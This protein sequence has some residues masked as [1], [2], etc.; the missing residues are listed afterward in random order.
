MVGAIGLEPTTPT[1][2]RWCSNQLSYAPEAAK[3]D[4]LAARGLRLR[5]APPNIGHHRAPRRYLMHHRFE[6]HPHCRPPLLCTAMRIAPMTLRLISLAKTS[7]MSRSSSASPAP[8]PAGQRVHRAAGAPQSTSMTR[9]GAARAAT[10]IRC[11][12]AVNRD[13]LAACHE[14]NDLVRRRRPAAARQAGQQRIHADHQHLAA[15]RCRIRA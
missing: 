7:E 6:G 10:Q 12:C 2:S 4:A 13:A 9:S 1:M 3:I 11:S 8:R 5:A 14:A 15:T